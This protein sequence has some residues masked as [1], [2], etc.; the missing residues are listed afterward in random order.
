MSAFI[1]IAVLLA[2]AA[3]AFLAVPL[4]RSGAR[5]AAVLLAGCLPLLAL[6]LYAANGDRAW[7]RPAAPAAAPMP[8]SLEQVVKL[9]ATRLEERPEDVSGWKLLGRSRAVLG[10]FAG[11]RDAFAQAYERTAGNDAEAVVG[12][13]EALVMLDESE[14]DG[15]AGR[16]FEAALRLAPDEP[17][18]LWYGGLSARRRGDG[19]TARQRWQALQRQE[20]PP[21]IRQAVADRLAELD[22]ATAPAPA[23][24][25][26]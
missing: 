2:L 6:G 13:G 5:L 7:T 19:D 3:A 24:D 14:L 11:A 18:A 17:R 15:Q 1:A 12:Y 20:L 8:G 22:R 16:L 4:W 26:G 23:V 9:L 25:S 10:D 21:E